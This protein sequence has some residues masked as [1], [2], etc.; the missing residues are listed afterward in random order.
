[1]LF[2]LAVF[3][4]GAASMAVEMCVS[5]LLGSIYG[6]SDIVWAGVIA[7]ALMSLAGG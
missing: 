4:A 6:S 1:M 5:R 3:A 7:M 2:Y